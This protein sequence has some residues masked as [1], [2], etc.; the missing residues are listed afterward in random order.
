[1]IILN[2]IARSVVY[3]CTEKPTHY[4]HVDNPK[5]LQELRQV[6]YNNWCMP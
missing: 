4:V 3:S 1:M 5:T 6:Q 2:K